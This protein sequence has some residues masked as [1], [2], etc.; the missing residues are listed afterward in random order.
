MI[1]DNWHWPQWALF[2]IMVIELGI[3]CAENGNPRAHWSGFRG[4]FN[5]VFLLFILYEGGFFK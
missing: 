2:I 4:I 1:T 3:Q 5:F